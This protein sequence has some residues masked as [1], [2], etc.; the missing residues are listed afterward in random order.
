MR[1]WI[2]SFGWIAIVLAGAMGCGKDQKT[3]AERDAEIQK[4]LQ[5]GA[6]KEQQMY[7]GMQKGMENVEK[8]VQDQKE[9]GK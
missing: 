4:T 5:E 1:H 2:K 8:S 9:K 3:S 6:R 7:Q